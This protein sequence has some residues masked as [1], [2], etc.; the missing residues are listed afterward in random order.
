MTFE[1]SGAISVLRRGEPVDP[2]LLSGVVGASLVPP[3]LLA[4]SSP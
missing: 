1:P 4:P 2:L 3:E